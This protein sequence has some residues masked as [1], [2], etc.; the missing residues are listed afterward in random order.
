MEHRHGAIQN[1]RVRVDGGGPGHHPDGPP[2]GDPDSLRGARG[3]GREHEKKE[4]VRRWPR[5][6]N[7][8]ASVLGHLLCPRTVVDEPERCPGV[9]A[10]QEVGL[11]RVREDDGAIGV[12][13]V[14]GERL[15]PPGVVGTDHH[16]ARQR[17]SEEEEDVF[18]EVVEQNA[19]VL[20]REA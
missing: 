6:G 20:A 2:L 5:I 18:G 12:A 8:R 11:R 19:D 3:A 13:Q 16:R 9:H 7:R 17:C 1:V 14:A 4:G 10:G 15:T